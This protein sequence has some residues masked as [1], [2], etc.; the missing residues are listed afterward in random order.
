M[1]K[2]AEIMVLAIVAIFAA[3][4]LPFC[5]CVDP[6][7]VDPTGGFTFPHGSIPFTIGTVKTTTTARTTTARTTTPTQTK[8][9]AKQTTLA[10][11]TSEPANPTLSQTTSTVTNQFT[12][13]KP[14][15]PTTTA[16]TATT[17][18]RNQ[19]S[20]ATTA[21]T[22]TSVTIENP[23]TTT[24]ENGTPSLP[25]PTSTGSIRH[26]LSANTIFWLKI[27][28]LCSG[29]LLFVFVIGLLVRKLI[30]KCKKRSSPT[31][32]PSVLMSELESRVP[33]YAHINEE[34]ELVDHNLPPLNPP[35]ARLPPVPLPPISHETFAYDY[36]T[37]IFDA[38]WSDAF[39]T[40][41]TYVRPRPVA[42]K[43]ASSATPSLQA[44]E[45]PSFK[46]EFTDIALD[47]IVVTDKIETGKK[48]SQWYNLSFVNHSKK[49]ANEESTVD[50]IT[51]TTA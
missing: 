43:I 2:L 19:T 24:F 14:T 33:L 36:H 23:T 32:N 35:A 38:K 40:E 5:N 17:T 7:I 11:S 3:E 49:Q 26:T 6:D 45:N 9:A 16:T 46:G 30:K 10:K 1:G 25:P 20:A 37:P 18:L 27:V 29:L 44:F 50:P 28:G 39:E 41:S 15:K 48:T 51:T 21:T 34:G 47:D 12:T 4:L 13:K 31:V 8:T 22:A 42:K